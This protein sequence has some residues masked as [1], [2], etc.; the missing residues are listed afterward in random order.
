MHVN[1]KKQRRRYAQAEVRS[2]HKGACLR[3]TLVVV[4]A[5]PL[6]CQNGPG[7]CAIVGSANAMQQGCGVVWR[8]KTPVTVQMGKEVDSY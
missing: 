4:T 7:W 6:A 2:Q 8:A 3:N 1:R 5:R